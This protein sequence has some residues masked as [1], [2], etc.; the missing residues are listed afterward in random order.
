MEG[1]EE[2]RLRGNDAQAREDWDIAIS[3]YGAGI[4]ARVVAGLLPDHRLFSNRS[5]AY[6][7]KYISVRSA[8]LNLRG[9]LALAINDAVQ[10]TTISPNWPKGWYRLFIAHFVHG[11]LPSAL[12]V[13]CDGLR[14]CPNDPDLTLAAWNLMFVSSSDLSPYLAEITDITPRSG[15]VERISA[16]VAFR[17]KD[18][19]TAVYRYTRAID[20]ALQSGVAPDRRN[21]CNRSAAWLQLAIIND[22]EQA[23]A[24][25][26]ADADRCIAIDSSWPKAWLRKG[27]AL[28]ED[29]RPGCA[30]DVFEHGLLRCPADGEL[31]AGLFQALNVIKEEG[32]ESDKDELSGSFPNTSQDLEEYEFPA[33]TTSPCGDFSAAA[34]E[35]LDYATSHGHT[36]PHLQPRNNSNNEYNYWF[37]NVPENAQLVPSGKEPLR[38]DPLFSHSMS[39]GPE[40][41]SA[42]EHRVSAGLNSGAAVSPLD[43]EKRTTQTL[44][45]LLGIS[46]KATDLEIKKA[47]RELA[48]LNH[49]DK[50]QGDPEATSKFQR[51]ARCTTITG[52]KAGNRTESRSLTRPRCSRW[53]LAATNSTD[54]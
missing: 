8:G 16:D 35:Q 50:N 15:D 1:C 33:R 48:R 43:S 25:A 21:Y 14:K 9:L 34:A 42:D 46:E 27:N 52:R 49:P 20:D 7:G 36:N 30:R 11:D 22:E 28:L 2:A 24:H 19:N 23:F 18:W 13:I 10:V 53:C 4:S 12:D 5:I 6:I 47:Y 3:A 38:S 44:Y 29:G 54:S 39:S 31:R 40:K 51:L 32:V 26:I 45:D 37:D 41:S 17:S